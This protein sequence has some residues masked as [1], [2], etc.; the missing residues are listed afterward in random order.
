MRSTKLIK[1]VC[2]N[3]TKKRFKI[4]S[5]ILTFAVLLACMPMAGL[6]AF[7]ASVVYGDADRNGG[8]DVQDVTCIQKY[9]AGLITEDELDLTA[10]KVLGNSDVGVEDVTC[11]QK[12]VAGI[13]DKFPAE[14]TSDTVQV[15]FNVTIPEA[16]S[17]GSDVSIGTNFNDW[18]PADTAWFMT[19]IDDF[20]YQLVTDID[21]Q[22]VGTT[23]QYKYTVQVEG[24]ES[25]WAQVEGGPTGGEIDNRTFT[26]EAEGNVVNDTVSMFKNQTGMNSVTGGTLETF[27]LDMPQ[28]SDGRTRNIRVWLPDGYDP[29]DT[30]KKYPVFYMHDGQNLFDSYTSFAGEWQVDEAITDM[31]AQG[32]EGSIVVGIDNSSD[33]IN[34]YTPNWP[35]VDSSTADDPSGDKY[36]AFI[37]ETLK[38]YIDS[39]YNVRTDKE[40]TGIGGSSMGGLISY[41]I[42]LEYPDVFGQVLV[43][44]PSFW[45]FSEDTISDVISSTDFSDTENLPKMFLYVGGES[46]IAPYIDFVKNTMID[47]GYP[48]EKINTLTDPSQTH[49]ESAWSKY[50][51]QAYQWLVGFESAPP[52]EKDFYRIYLDTSYSQWETPYIAMWI[53]E[54]NVVPMTP[55]EGEEYLFYYDLPKE[56]TEFLFRANDDLSQWGDAASANVTFRPANENMVYVFD[57]QASDGKYMG[58][59]QKLDQE[60]E[61]DTY[62]VYFDVSQANWTDA[63]ICMWIGGENYVQMTPVEGKDGVYFYDLPKEQVEF[64]LRADLDFSHWGEYSSLNITFSPENEN[65]VFV[66]SGQSGDGKYG[67]S[68]QEYN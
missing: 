24:Q 48:E 23:V 17:E 33:R 8:V 20:H 56:Q 21:A 1:E 46:S 38:P 13:I 50:F 16:L 6:S 66:L 25:I 29:E 5:I 43:F 11:I 59:W 30:E 60:P 26:L 3:M 39:H 22:Y 64:L 36:A 35:D 9:I 51:P 44:S 32:Y 37:V 53:G 54:T 55:V 68:W 47:Q 42:G 18:N 52:I 12:Y 62:R 49:S 10:A 4:M 58:S 57:E 67:G 34:E 63:Y 40:S 14:D 31:I 15:I 45:L 41:Y 27:K 7:A 61:K 2:K 65:M 19:K 28:Y